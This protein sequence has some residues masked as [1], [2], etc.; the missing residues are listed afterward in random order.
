[1]LFRV[2]WRD[3]A[4]VRTGVRGGNLGLLCVALHVSH[5]YT[6]K[7][8]FDNRVNSGL[9]KVGTFSPLLLFLVTF[10]G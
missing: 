2:A 8:R 7:A 3:S 5:T 9:A 10:R 4:D 6:H 1:M